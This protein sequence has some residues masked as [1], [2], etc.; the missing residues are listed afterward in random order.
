M[1]SNPVEKYLV[2]HHRIPGYKKLTTRQ[3][4]DHWKDRKGKDKDLSRKDYMH[5][6]KLIGLRIQY[7]ILNHDWWCRLPKKFGFLYIR[8]KINLKR[9]ATHYVSLW[10]TFRLVRY[11]TTKF[12]LRFMY[13]TAVVTKRKT[14]SRKERDFGA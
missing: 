8:K 4:Y 7:Y 2:D 1:S 10:K 5:I 13:R 12:D 14:K 9:R 3:T 11:Y 6:M